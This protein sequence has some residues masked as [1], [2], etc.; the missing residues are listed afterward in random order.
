MSTIYCLH[1]F[2]MYII[3]DL[4]VALSEERRSLVTQR[5]LR[6]RDSKQVARAGISRSVTWL[7]SRGPGHVKEDRAVA[8][9]WIAPLLLAGPCRTSM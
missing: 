4:L 5:W 1:V 7:G 6:V 2:D 9:S 3:D 8:R